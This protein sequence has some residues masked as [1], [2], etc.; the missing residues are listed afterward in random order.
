MAV[1]RREIYSNT[2][3]GASVLINVEETD[4]VSRE[5][6]LFDASMTLISTRPMESREQELIGHNRHR[7]QRD[8]DWLQTQRDAQLLPPSGAAAVLRGIIKR[9]LVTSSPFEAQVRADRVQGVVGGTV[10]MEV[11]LNA[12]PITGLAGFTIRARIRNAAIAKFTD[13]TFP[14]SFPLASHLPDP[15][16]GQALT[17]IS[18]VDLGAVIG[19][20]E[21]NILLAT[22]EI[23]FLSV[24]VSEV[25]ID[26][27][28]LDDDSGDD[29]ARSV[30]DTRIRVN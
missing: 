5:V 8:A 29:I 15:V 22:L 27:V 18:G 7:S 14:A 16:D 30:E 3:P 28:A 24:G 2:S 10:S 23:Q 26:V 6:R 12:T 20:E 11:R 9:L 1:K 19:A 25:D 17:N 4:D 21:T 13:V